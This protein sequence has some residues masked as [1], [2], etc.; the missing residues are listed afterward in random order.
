MRG[1]LHLFAP[2]DLWR[3][4]AAWPVRD[5]TR[6]P[7]WLKYFNVTIDSSMRSRT[8]IGEVLDETP[9]TGRS[10]RQRCRADQRPLAWLAAQL[11]LGPVPQARRRTRPACV[12]A[13]SGRNVT[14]VSPTRWLGKPPNRGPGSALRARRAS[15]SVASD[16]SGRQPRGGREVVG[17]REPAD[18]VESAR[19]RR[20][21]HRRGRHRGP[22]RLGQERRRQRDARET[23]RSVRLPPARSLRQRAS[24]EDG[25]PL[26]PVDREALV[27]RTAGGLT[28]VVLVDGRVE[29]TWEIGQGAKGAIEVQPFGK[30]RGGAHSEIKAGG[31]ASRGVPGPTAGGQGQAPARL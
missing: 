3:F 12:R 9:R 31:G 21:R 1:T 30:L 17:H 18:D 13:G 8:A 24:A 25:C 7:A 6:S 16:L 29:G 10:S 19:G 27:R 4:V 20:S 28:P 15:R 22:A 14:F 23:S 11:R 2:D 5:N 26:L